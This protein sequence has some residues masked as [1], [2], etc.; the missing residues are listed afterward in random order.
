VL[1]VADTCHDQSNWN[2]IFVCSLA[3]KRYKQ[4]KF[5]LSGFASVFVRTECL[6]DVPIYMKHVFQLLFFK[7][8]MVN[9]FLCQEHKYR[10]NYCPYYYLNEHV[11][12]YVC[13][14]H[15]LNNFSM[16]WISGHEQAFLL[17]VLCSRASGLL[18]FT[19]V[20]ICSPWTLDFILFPKLVCTINVLS[21]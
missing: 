18:G 1:V 19:L 17:Y 3:C 6:I 20:L 13:W 4:T 11:G 12:E 10:I 2:L 15:S 14:Q 16:D 9:I 21:C 7:N 8:Y 5:N